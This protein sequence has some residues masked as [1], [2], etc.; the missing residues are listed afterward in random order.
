MDNTAHSV[1]NQI[2][3]LFGE[4]ISLANVPENQKQELFTKLEE[5]ITLN[6]LGRLFDQLSEAEQALLNQQELKTKEDLFVFFSQSM[7]PEEFSKI[8]SQAVEEVIGKFL[9]KIESQNVTS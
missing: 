2:S 7:S 3:V 4:L 9:D 1:Q 8:A 5:A 6:I